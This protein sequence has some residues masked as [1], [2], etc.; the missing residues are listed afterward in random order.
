MTRFGCLVLATG[1]TWLLTNIASKAETIPKTAP[2]CALLQCHQV[3]AMP[4]AMKACTSA[5]NAADSCLTQSTMA[6]QSASAT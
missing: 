4:S 3:K 1:V 6:F 2:V 5:V